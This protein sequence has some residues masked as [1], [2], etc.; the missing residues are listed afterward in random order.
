MPLPGLHCLSPV[1]KTLGHI[2]LSAR[3]FEAKRMHELL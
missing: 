3:C 1:S 2:D